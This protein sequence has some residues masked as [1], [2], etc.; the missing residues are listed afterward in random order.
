MPIEH[1]DTE[2]IALFICGDLDDHQ[3]LK[4]GTHLETCPQCQE[5]LRKTSLLLAKISDTALEEPYN[6]PSGQPVR[7]NR[8]DL[9]PW[10][11]AAAVILIFLSGMLFQRTIS[12]PL[13][14][15]TSSESL[16]PNK[17]AIDPSLEDIMQLIAKAELQDR[18]SNGLARGLFAIRAASR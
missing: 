11:R 6:I 9:R 13:A 4:I 14:A 10:I 7:S 3:L 16:E 12:P 1:Y 8:F 2:E 17:E 5:N 18:G 15:T